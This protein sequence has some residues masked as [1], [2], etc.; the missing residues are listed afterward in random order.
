V[1]QDRQPAGR[2][3]QPPR[4][5][6]P[7]LCSVWSSLIDRLAGEPPGRQYC[8]QMVKYAVFLNQSVGWH[9]SWLALPRMP[10]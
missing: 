10:V 9:P 3:L 6:S 8:L 1:P 2:E 5:V 4:A 7:P